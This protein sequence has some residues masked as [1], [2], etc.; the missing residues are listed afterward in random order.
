MVS[1][2]TLFTQFNDL[3]DG[4]L[5]LTKNMGDVYNITKD[6]VCW[7]Y[8]YADMIHVFKSTK[9]LLV[10]MQVSDTWFL[11]NYTDQY[12]RSGASA[13][14]IINPRGYEHPNPIQID[15]YNLLLEHIKELLPTTKNIQLSIYRGRKEL[16]IE[17][18]NIDFGA[19]LTIGCDDLLECIPTWYIHNFQNEQDW[20]RFCLHC[21][22]LGLDVPESPWDEIKYRP[23]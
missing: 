1:Q 6:T 21:Y 20:S 13:C 5:F 12:L 19:K 7:L 8:K 3:Y 2:E 18:Q 17:I 4:V 15:S 22:R 14:S 23:I 9:Y 10:S 11:V 16:P